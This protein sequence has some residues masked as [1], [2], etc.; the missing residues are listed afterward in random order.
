MKNVKLFLSAALFIV[1]AAGAFATTA[2]KKAVTKSG[3]LSTFPGYIKQG[4]N[5]VL[6]NNCTDVPNAVLCTETQTGGAQ[7]FGITDA[8]HCAVQLWRLPN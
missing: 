8:T 1:A 5:C 4:P 7:V 2:S 3:V 6:K